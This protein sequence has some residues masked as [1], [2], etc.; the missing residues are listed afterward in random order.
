MDNKF[1]VFPVYFSQNKKEG[2]FISV[3]PRPRQ[4]E[5]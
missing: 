2:G 4:N 5:Y 3:E 1:G